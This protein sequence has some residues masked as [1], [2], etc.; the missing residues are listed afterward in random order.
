MQEAGARPRPSS[1][2]AI[3]RRSAAYGTD[4][5][6]LFCG[7]VVVQGLLA[8]LGLH[9]LYTPPGGDA[10]PT[11]GPLH[12]WVFSTAT[13]PFLIYFALRFR[14]AS[15][16]TVGMRRFDL[17]VVRTTGERVGSGRAVVRSAILLVPFELNHVILFHVVPRDDLPSIWSTMGF[18]G[19]LLSIG[20][21]LGS[22]AFTRRGRSIHDLV[23]GTIVRR[24][25]P[26]SSR[27][28]PGRGA[29]DPPRSRVAR[30]GCDSSFTGSGEEPGLMPPS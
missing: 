5:L 19:V 22:I 13:V 8:L 28:D 4:C 24:R 23:A 20:L 25:N 11:G 26:G 16:A 9:P 29:S 10:P 21:Y 17:E 15:G 1:I 30:V 18:V 2:A 7:L 3:A 14:S 27:G 6:L 12:Q